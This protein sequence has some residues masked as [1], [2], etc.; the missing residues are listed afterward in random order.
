MLSFCL[1]KGLVFTQGQGSWWCWRPPLFGGFARTSAS[2]LLKHY[3]QNSS[4][5]IRIEFILIISDS[6]RFN[7]LAPN[8]TS[9]QGLPFRLN[10]CL[11]KVPNVNVGKA[12]KDFQPFAVL[13]E[14]SFQNPKALGPSGSFGEVWAGS[15][16]L[17]EFSARAGGP[18]AMVAGRP[19]QPRVW[20]ARPCWDLALAFWKRCPRR[21]RRSSEPHTAAIC[22]GPYLHQPAFV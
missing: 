7:N 5:I 3:N 12:G 15:L 10:G 13:R 8:D 9:R 20:D 14:P 1:F 16:M 21:L 19:S 11:R 17:A 4:R 6:I 22:T 18:S 2:D